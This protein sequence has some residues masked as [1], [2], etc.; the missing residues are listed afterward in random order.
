[1]ICPDLPRTRHQSVVIHPRPLVAPTQHSVLGSFPP[2]AVLVQRVLYS[3]CI[4]LLSE[5]LG[6]GALGPLLPCTRTPSVL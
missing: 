3:Y 6:F 1:M 5:P 4:A 2:L